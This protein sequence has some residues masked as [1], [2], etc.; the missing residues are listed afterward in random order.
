M[1]KKV[2]KKL[3][4]YGIQVLNDPEIDKKFPPSKRNKIKYKLIENLSSPL[5]VDEI[6]EKY[7]VVELDPE[8]KNPVKE[9]PSL[10]EY[11]IFQSE[12]RT[13]NKEIITTFSR[14]FI[15]LCFPPDF[16]FINQV[17]NRVVSNILKWVIYIYYP[18]DVFNK[19]NT[20]ITDKLTDIGTLKSPTFE[21]TKFKLPPEI[22]E[23]IE[24]LRSNMDS[25][26][27]QEIDKA[28][29]E[30]Y[31][32]VQK[33]L[34]SKGLT[35]F[36]LIDSGT[37]G[38][39]DDLIQLF[40]SWGYGVDGEG[41][42]TPPVKNSLLKGLTP[43]EMYYGANKAITAAYLKSVGSAQPGH[44]AKIIRAALNDVKFDPNLE[45]CGTKK[46]FEL[47]VTDKNKS[48][49]IG[50]YYLNEKT[51]KLEEITEENVSKL[52][53]K[54]IKLR[55]PIYCKSE[56]FCKTCIGPWLSEQLY[57]PEANNNSL[58]S[59]LTGV[60]YNLILNQYQKI[61]HSRITAGEELDFR[62][63]FEKYYLK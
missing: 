36:D 61:S 12:G 56:K 6:Y 42:L 11:I 60:V 26:E 24:H 19:V 47:L 14:L 40:I 23:K 20:C 34:K 35:F 44:I 3:Q 16:P 17:I 32:E 43:E 48:N 21:P 38:K 4:E 62:K 30:I 58:W 2:L 59:N 22:E 46:Y 15:N 49:L 50:R 18:E 63:E 25:M 41:N 37:K 8:T 13:D 33:Y 54:K 51:K 5:T 45:D 57:I 52:I 27:P 29:Y 9:R 10:S 53:G 7:F 39:K 1:N 31:D 55:S 28:L